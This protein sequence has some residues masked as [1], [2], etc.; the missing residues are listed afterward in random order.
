MQESAGYLMLH[1]RF[2]QFLR[3]VQILESFMTQN[4]CITTDTTLK[5]WGIFEKVLLFG[6]GYWDIWWLGHSQNLT[7][8]RFAVAQ[9]VIR[10]KMRCTC[11]TIFFV[12]TTKKVLSHQHC[13]GFLCICV[14]LTQGCTGVVNVSRHLISKGRINWE[15]YTTVH[16][17]VKY[18]IRWTATVLPKLAI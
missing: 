5:F 18:K 10:I 17:H 14:S 15:T 12:P 11:F 9:Y 3:E 2:S 13:E 7:S 4:I 6:F 16:G 1:L 8:Q